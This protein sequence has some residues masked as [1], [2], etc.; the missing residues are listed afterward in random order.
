MITK[1]NLYSNFPYRFVLVN[2]FHNKE[3]TE[4]LS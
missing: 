4:Q 3:A 2:L 1:N